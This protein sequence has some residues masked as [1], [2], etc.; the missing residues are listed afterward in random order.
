VEATLSL[1]EELLKAEGEQALAAIT[2]VEIGSYDVAIEI[3]GR[4]PEKWHPRTRET[5]DHSFPYCVAVSLMD[6]AVTRR[7]FDKKRLAD[8]ALSSLMQ[9][10]RVVP[11]PE[12]MGR[13]PL[14]MPTRITLRTQSGKE[15]V[16]Q[17][18]YP[19]GHPRNPMP[20]HDVEEKFLRLAAGQL[21]RTR[22]RKVI[23]LVWQL[24]LVKDISTLM[25]LLKLKGRGSG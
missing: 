3:I 16:K 2:D 22:A 9:K 17:A 23:D 20:D 21:D 25:P 24:E 10:I 19:L 11:Q 15:Y 1:R 8:P 18:D 4:D 7:S 5:A 12:F 6:G 14:A 13:Y